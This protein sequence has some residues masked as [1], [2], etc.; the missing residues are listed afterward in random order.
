MFSVWEL[1]LGSCLSMR[2]APWGD[3]LGS[4]VTSGSRRPL[5]AASCQESSPCRC[6]SV[7]PGQLP[8]WVFLVWSHRLCSACVGGESSQLWFC[9]PGSVRAPLWCFLAKLRGRDCES[10]GE[11]ERNLVRVHL[12]CRGTCE[13][14]GETPPLA[15]KLRDSLGPGDLASAH[16]SGGHIWRAAALTTRHCRSQWQVVFSLAYWLAQFTWKLFDCLIE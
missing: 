11:S 13:G 10:V 15:L 3:L 2:R 8:G 4:R 7:S 9:W 1:C 5:P 16:R 14:R 6:G 12:V